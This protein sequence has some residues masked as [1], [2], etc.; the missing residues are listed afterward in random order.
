MKKLVA[1]LLTAAMTVGML[2]GCGS[3][4]AE[5]GAATSTEAGT[6]NNAEGQ[7]QSTIDMTAVTLM[8]DG[9]LTVG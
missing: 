7:T 1:M 5:S 3:K 6:G 8:S 9:V 2:A 4:P